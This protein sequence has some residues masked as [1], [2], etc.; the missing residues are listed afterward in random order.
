MQYAGFRSVMHSGIGRIKSLVRGVQS[1]MLTGVSGCAARG[2]CK[3]IRNS[4]L[5][6]CCLMCTAALQAQV[7]QSSAALET[8]HAPLQNPDRLVKR[9]GFLFVGEISRNEEIHQHR[10]ASGVERKIAYRVTQ[11]LW[12]YPDSLLGPGYTVSKGFTDCRRTSL[13]TWEAG[14]RVIAYCEALPG[15]GY[16]CLAPVMFTDDRLVRVKYWIAELAAREGNPELLKMHYLLHDS[17]ELAPSRP[18]LL[19]GKVTWATPKQQ[20]PFPQTI[21][22]LPTMRV[23]VSRLLWGYYKELEVNAVCPHRDCSNV[24]VGGKAI[25]YCEAMGVYNGPPAYCALATVDPT[26]ENV[27]RVDQWAAQARQRQPALIVERIRKYLATRSP[28]PRSVPSVYR[29]HATWVGKADNGLPFVHF[30]DTTGR[31]SE[32]VNLLIQRHYATGAPVAIEVGKPMI[33]FCLQRDDVATS[34]M[35]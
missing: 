35:K 16:K 17:L 11:V 29:G 20:F 21:T 6:L 7:A 23:S 13:P 25:V 2:P 9:R 33:T 22:I 31:L 12:D 4:V 19:L 14:T 5:S 24:A 28:D 10:C 30:A 32:P 8:L 15:Q 1:F 26:D 3:S 27:Q 34:E 18:L